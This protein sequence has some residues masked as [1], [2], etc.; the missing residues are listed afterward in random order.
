MQTEARRS[1]MR[2]IGSHFFQ[3]GHLQD[4]HAR[5]VHF[6]ADENSLKDGVGL[7]A[8]GDDVK[9]FL[10]RVDGQTKDAE[11]FLADP[12]A[13][14]VEN[15]RALCAGFLRRL[16][17]TVGS[18]APGLELTVTVSILPP[19]LTFSGWAKPRSRVYG[20]VLAIRSNINA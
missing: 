4:T 20:H 17:N 8:G 2:Y 10:F 11:A 13:V 14:R 18:A 1:F 12:G 6:G 19:L 7:I 16:H 9:H 5:R 15:G 3:L